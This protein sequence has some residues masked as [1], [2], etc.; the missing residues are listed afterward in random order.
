M[1]N[2]TGCEVTRFEERSPVKL[3]LECGS[4]KHRTSLCCK[5][6]CLVCG[7]KAHSDAN[8]PIDE[9]AKCI[10]CKGTHML[11]NCK[12]PNHLKQ[13]GPPTNNPKAAA[14]PKGK[15]PKKPTSNPIISPERSGESCGLIPYGGV[16]CPIKFQV[17][18]E[19]G[20]WV[21]SE[22]WIENFKRDIG[23]YGAELE[24][25]AKTN[26]KKKNKVTLLPPLQPLS[27]TPGAGSSAACPADVESNMMES[28]D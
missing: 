15:E 14:N 11:N 19:K 22:Q 5:P 3:C 26:K 6:K 27:Q 1:A 16:H 7:S 8:H 13:V 10:N 18:N 25:N 2:Y 20:K 28:N 23:N 9:P 24:K 4:L 17:K 12:C 21:P